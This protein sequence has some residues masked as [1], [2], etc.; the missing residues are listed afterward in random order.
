MKKIFPLLLL[1]T[2]SSCAPRLFAQVRIEN[3]GS[4]Y[5]SQRKSSLRTLPDIPSNTANSPSHSFDVLSYSINANLY[6]C[7]FSPY[8]KN[9]NAKI[10]LTFR[11]DSALNSIVLDALN[12][13][14]VIDSVRLAGIT[15]VHSDNLLQVNLD[16]TYFPGEIAQV[17]I[18]YR[19][20]DVT[21]YGFYVSGGMVFT[22]SEP[23]GAR[24]WLPCWDKPSDK[25]TLDLTAR[26]PAAARLGSNGKLMDSA[27][28]GDTLI[29]HWASAHNLATYLMV[30]T[31]R[32]NYNLDIVYWHKL[33]NPA[34]SVPMR[35]YYNAGEDPN[36]IKSMI[37][38]LTTYFS[39][40]F[41][42]HPFQK[43]GF[44]ALNNLFVWGGMENQTLTSI[45]PNCWSEWLITHEYAHQWFGDMIT[46]G[47]WA[48]IWLNEGFA[49][50]AEAFWWE[51]SGG[52]AAYKN[53]IL[54]DANSYLA[55]NPGWAI[56][57]PSW[58]VTTPSTGILFNWGI[59]YCKG[60]C[61]LHLLRYTLGDSLFF[62]T[63]QAYCADTNLRFKSAT[64]SD[65]KEKVNSVTG[66]DYTWFFN[67]WIYSPNHPAY[68]NNYFFIN[69]GDG[70]WK[71][72]FVTSQT[73]ACPQFF[74]MPIEIRIQFQQGSDTLIR[75]MNTT[76]YQEYDWVFRKTPVSLVFD[77]DDEIV[78]KT[79]NTIQGK[80]WTGKS[81]D[82]WYDPDNWNPNGVP[83]SEPVK[84]P[85]TALIM[86]NVKNSGMTCGSLTI[87]SGAVITILP[88][89]NLSVNG[90]V[91]IQ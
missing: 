89:K 69:M 62:A 30:M 73:Q 29:Y 27:F 54:S 25:A 34:D 71:V 3:K 42:E 87:D 33:S 72:S 43:N 18:I 4:Y 60:S 64:I 20:K 23:E 24:C 28:S 19:H 16:R 55:Y 47:T 35:F 58:A 17:R 39:E 85:S 86:P 50:W 8:P 51:H 48:D 10:T 80:A 90:M 9:F 21:D 84:I 31:A 91:I 2:I 63:L 88:G 68:E 79:S 1:V 6:S 5:C 11:V 44:A 53:D 45:C 36:P 83:V 67:E 41:C 52:Y 13:S 7:F 81:S 82:N 70:R 46:C 74:S 76:N 40:H 22:D 49:S 56:S 32:I 59:T 14:L 15:F 75:V 78:L 66:Q 61:A 57:D 37:G 12:S 38:P 77:P 65:F 26:V